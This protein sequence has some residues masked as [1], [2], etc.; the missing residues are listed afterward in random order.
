MLDRDIGRVTLVRPDG[1]RLHRGWSIVP[2][3]LEPGFAGRLRADETGFAPLPADHEERDGRVLLNAA[4]LTAKIRLHP[5]G[6]RGAGRDAPT[7]PGTKA[8]GTAGTT[9]TTTAGGGAVSID[10]PLGRLPPFARA[11]AVV[12]ADAPDLPFI[13]AVGVGVRSGSPGVVFA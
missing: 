13:R 6:A 5:F 12:T 8:A 2:G 11:E 7:C 9:A 4:G 10:A 1:D 3:G